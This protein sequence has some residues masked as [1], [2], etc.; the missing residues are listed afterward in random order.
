MTTEQRKERIR[1]LQNGLDFLK[2][3]IVDLLLKENYEASDKGIIN[4]VLKL[5]KEH[6]E[7]LDKLKKRH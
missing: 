2:G 7:Q 1:I 5:I 6:E 3:R 4:E